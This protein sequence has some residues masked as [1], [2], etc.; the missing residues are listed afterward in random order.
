MRKVLFK[1]WIPVEYKPTGRDY[2]YQKETRVEGTGCYSSEF[3]ES[4]FF[5]QWI[6]SSEEGTIGV[7]VYPIAL[8]EIWNGEILELPTN[9]IKFVDTASFL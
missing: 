9:A 2:P 8:V 7:I 1:K 4:G 6:N 5:H 3:T